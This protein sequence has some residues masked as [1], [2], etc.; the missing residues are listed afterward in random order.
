MTDTSS[1]IDLAGR[2]LTLRNMTINGLAGADVIYGTAGGTL[3]LQNCIINLGTST[4]TLNNNSGTSTLSVQIWDDVWVCGAAGSTL[5]LSGIL[6]SGAYATI[7]IQANSRLNMDSNTT[8]LYDQPSGASYRNKLTFGN[9]NTSVLS[10]HNATLSALA[11]GTN[12]GIFLN[13]GTLVFDGKTSLSNASGTSS[14]NGIGFGSGLTVVVIPGAQ[15]SN[16]SG[17]ITYGASS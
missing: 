10:L 4:W 8:L 11:S 1:K 6:V 17:V 15:L 5:E 2:T 13:S 12:M 7:A 14:S 3:R 16:P 9:A